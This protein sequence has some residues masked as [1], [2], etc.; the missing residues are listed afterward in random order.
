MGDKKIRGI[1]ERKAR[2]ALFF[3]L[4]LCSGLFFVREN[5]MIAAA[6]TT[7]AEQ[8]EGST[9]Q[10]RQVNIKNTTANL[11]PEGVSYSGGSGTVEDPYQIANE[12]DFYNIRYHLDAN[13][14]QTGDITL[15]DY[16]V[17]EP[18]QGF[19]GTYDGGGHQI[20]AAE[21]RITEGLILNKGLGL[22]GMIQNATIKNINIDF[23]KY[24]VHVTESLS[25]HR[26][27]GILVGSAKGTNTIENCRISCPEYKV[28]VPEN[29]KQD[30][31]TLAAAC[32]VGNLDEGKNLF[33]TIRNCTING[34]NLTIDMKL[35]EANGRNNYIRSGLVVGIGS[36]GA[37]ENVSVE[38]GSLSI[39]NFHVGQGRKAMIQSGTFM[40]LTQGITVTNCSSSAELYVKNCQ[41]DLLNT[42]GFAGSD[43]GVSG[44][45]QHCYAAGNL[46]LMDS[47][48]K[49]SF[50]AGGFSGTINRKLV[51]DNTTTS[52]IY[53][54]N[55]EAAKIQEIGGFSGQIGPGA[56]PLTGNAYKVYA[57]TDLGRIGDPSKETENIKAGIAQLAEDYTMI[58]SYEEFKLIGST[59]TEGPYSYG[60]KYYQTSDITIPDGT[61]Y[62]PIGNDTTPFTGI[63]DGGNHGIYGNTVSIQADLDEK[64][65]GGVG[66]FGTIQNATVRNMKVSIT[67]MDIQVMACSDGHQGFSL[68]VGAMRNFS[69]NAMENI[70]ITD[71]CLSVT[72]SGEENSS[73]HVESTA[74]GLLCGRANSGRGSNEDPYPCSIKNCTVKNSDLSVGVTFS[75]AGI[76][77]YIRSGMAVGYVNNMTL[78]GVRVEGGTFT[79]ERFRNPNG[80]AVIQ[81]GCFSGLVSRDCTIKNCYN[82]GSLVIRDCNLNR[83]VIGGLFGE[84]GFDTNEYLNNESKGTLDI[85]KTTG[86]EMLGGGLG[87]IVGK[88]AKGN[89]ISTNIRI[90]STSTIQNNQ[91]GGFAYKITDNSNT[92]DIRDNYYVIYPDTTYPKTCVPAPE[93]EPAAS[94]I[95]SVA[96][97]NVGT[98][99]GQTVSIGT[100]VKFRFTVT[101]DPQEQIRYQWQVKRTPDAGWEDIAGAVEAE[102]ATEAAVSSMDQYQYR[103]KV[104]YA[105]SGLEDVTNSAILRVLNTDYIPITSYEDFAKIGDRTAD[106]MYPLNGNYRQMNDFEIP[107]GQVHHPIG[108]GQEA[109]S[110]TYDGAGFRI[111]GTVLNITGEETG[112]GADGDTGCGLFGTLYQA[113]LKNITLE[114]LDVNAG[115][116]MVEGNRQ[117]GFGVLAGRMQGACELTGIR[118][119]ACKLHVSFRPDHAFHPELIASGILAGNSVEKNGQGS[120]ADDVQ[121]T[122]CGIQHEI[123]ENIT[124]ATLCSGLTAGQWVNGELQKIVIDGGELQ[125]TGLKNE[126]IQAGT[127]VGLLSGGTL[128]DS[129]SSAGLYVEGANINSLSAGG[130]AGALQLQSDSLPL[131]VKGNR[132]LGQLRI[133]N[134][135]T[136][137]K[138]VIGGGIGALYAKNGPE[139]NIKENEI[140]GTIEITDPSGGYIGGFAGYLS[141]EQQKLY[142]SGNTYGMADYERTGK[143]SPLNDSN[144][145]V[146][147]EGI[148]KAQNTSDWIPIYSY[149]EFEKIGIDAAYPIDGN[150]RQMNDFSIPDNSVHSPVGSSDHPFSG[151]YDGQG[152]QIT[153][154]HVMVYSGGAF[155]ERLGSGLFGYI[156]NATIRNTR[157]SITS[158]TVQLMECTGRGH[159]GFSVLAGGLSGPSNRLENNELKDTALLVWTGGIVS[160]DIFV[161]TVA[162][163]LLAGMVWGEIGGDNQ[164]KDCHVINSTVTVDYQT[165]KGN[166]EY[167]YVRSGMAVGYINKGTR[168]ENTHVSGGKFIVQ[169]FQ[170]S[171]NTVGI[172][173]C[174]AFNGINTE[175]NVIYTN[176]STSADLQVKDS[177]ANFYW[178]GG[179]TGYTSFSGGTEEYR[180]QNNTAQ[181]NIELSNLTSKG[182]SKSYIGG[183]GGNIGGDARDNLAG[184]NISIQG[185]NDLKDANLG[186]FAGKY[187]LRDS[188][189]IQNNYYRVYEDTNYPRIMEPN[190]IPEAIMTGV[191]PIG[192]GEVSG[193]DKTAPTLLET[194][195]T[196]DDWTAQNI[197]IMVSAR[198]DWSRSENLQYSW[199]GAAYSKTNTYEATANGSYTLQIKDEAG[200]ISDI[201]YIHIGNIDREAPVIQGV[202]IRPDGWTLQEVALSVEA[203]DAGCGGITYRL[204]DSGDFKEN[205]AVAANGTYSLYAKDT[206]GNISP[207]F[208]ITVDNIAS[209]PVLGAPKPKEELVL[210]GVSAV[211]ENVIQ[212]EGVPAG[213]R[214]QWQTDSGTGV[215][216]NIQ[217]ATQSSYTTPRATKEMDEWK[218]RVIVTQEATNQSITSDAT[219]LHVCY[220]P[221]PP[222]I[223][224]SREENV[225]GKEKITF[226]LIPGKEISG[227]QGLQYQI[228]STSGTWLDYEEGTDVAVDVQGAVSVYARAYNAVRPGKVSDL[229]SFC[230]MWDQTAPTTTDFLIQA[231]A[232]TET[233]K[234][235]FQAID[236][237]DP[238]K[239]TTGCGIDT[240]QANSV[241]YAKANSEEPDKTKW[242]WQPAIYENGKYT[243]SYSSDETTAYYYVRA[244]DRLGNQSEP[245]LAYDH[246][247]LIHVAV[248]AKMMVAWLP[249]QKDRVFFSPDYRIVNLSSVA[250]TKVMLAGF[251]ASEGNEFRL[252]TQN[253]V[254]NERTLL[255]TAGTDGGA[256]TSGDLAVERQLPGDSVWT[257]GTIPINGYGSYT[258][259]ST[260][261]EYPYELPTTKRAGFQ[262]NLKLYAGTGEVPTLTEKK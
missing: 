183:F 116:N 151:S 25:G 22:F 193:T 255:I 36:Y 68:V 190:P 142:I 48:V 33:T 131:T 220:A 244:A 100:K 83:I 29:E 245:V 234:V 216:Q 221:D 167:T 70:E 80:Q 227:G 219:T 72:A 163:G 21:V 247:T 197:Q 45:Y 111:T 231:D 136:K 17:W 164:I 38:G 106:S 171:N 54:T 62:E 81:S 150:Y 257:M 6:Q 93:Q 34:C 209:L 74:A 90:D 117:Y 30:V 256:F 202:K 109:F 121:I 98:I 172:V 137:D 208:S 153:G 19:A 170:A 104:A 94:G 186:G 118:L 15:A 253:P 239:K 181:S 195:W 211:F 127:I 97:M 31:E 158:F 108:D 64:H 215:F 61:L 24:L 187:D 44:G 218:Y 242:N 194:V 184:G 210:E 40:G 191:I 13:Y 23:Q 103:C 200:N 9:G 235:T 96:P 52:N 4:F 174:G 232:A 42:G 55:I 105:A 224:L 26:G 233:T 156:R 41:V 66:L 146:V 143:K 188:M 182:G 173:Q 144:S 32:I 123:P 141:S 92:D 140:T 185:S 110:G 39:E 122:N 101:G 169:N 5:R 157:I 179:F 168:V 225:W 119:S 56:S 180:F 129:S 115:I 207:A 258:F 78:E 126:T 148:R 135:V 65:K 10:I 128:S 199:N 76:Y 16:A 214:Y 204:G 59:G 77:N 249:E 201:Y 260:S 213:C 112:K 155:E 47:T 73:L 226:Q 175:G 79:I 107:S 166:N 229:V 113:V 230:S 67:N 91:T 114:N 89:R 162:T 43:Y 51:C 57:D 149:E 133:L 236:W 82:S 88:I 63:Y 198:D 53:V 250:E 237:I 152:F 203:Y 12:T 259:H 27:V 176:C 124:A 7:V 217:G 212:T 95:Q 192:E 86:D 178:L 58:S 49:D 246:R 238:V 228:G 37:I 18:I 1:A 85:V 147:R 134:C 206:L 120:H 160:P 243:F 35:G 130:L 223:R 125:I 138:T 240:T 248:P 145:P 196:P 28:E 132:Y 177:Q 60:G 102:Y 205:L 154:N 71:S 262:M 252:T 161:D 165:A 8:T 241:Q 75:K 69:K 87:A 254:E 251:T 20:R 222:E 99:P 14:L 3:M 159:R 50:Y 189:V 11:S 261:E 139:C 46:Y 2:T 84:G